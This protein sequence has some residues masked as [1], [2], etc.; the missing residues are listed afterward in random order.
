MYLEAYLYNFSASRKEYLLNFSTPR[1]VRENS[2]QN[3]ENVTPSIL[4]QTSQKIQPSHVLT[5]INTAS[6]FVFKWEPSLLTGLL[7]HINLY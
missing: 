6:H 7:R 2:M 5:G 4:S 3:Y 1:F